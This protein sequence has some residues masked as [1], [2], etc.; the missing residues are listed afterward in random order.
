MK[1]QRSEETPQEYQKLDNN[2]I[3]IAHFIRSKNTKP[4]QRL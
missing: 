3:C 2:N 4:F 1:K